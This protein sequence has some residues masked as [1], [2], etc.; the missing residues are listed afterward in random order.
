MVQSYG[1]HVLVPFT[2]APSIGPNFSMIFS[3]LVAVPTTRPT[4]AN[5]VIAM[6]LVC[7]RTFRLPRNTGC[8]THE[9][10]MA[11]KAMPLKEMQN[12]PT[13]EINRSI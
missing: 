8:C 5:T 11:G 12:A 10:I 3:M 7:T 2:L 1:Y 6:F 4:M 13:N 9:S